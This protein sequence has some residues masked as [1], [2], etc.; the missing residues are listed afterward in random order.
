[1]E[2]RPAK[3]R[4]EEMSKNIVS[5]NDNVNDNAKSKNK[6]SGR[7]IVKVACHSNGS[8]LHSSVKDK[9]EKLQVHIIVLYYM[10]KYYLNELFQ[11][12]RSIKS[13]ITVV[14]SPKFQ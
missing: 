11:W 5:S 9:G 13:M 3:R 14:G 8:I 6:N 12:F 7:K 1:M 4:R 10:K 2:T